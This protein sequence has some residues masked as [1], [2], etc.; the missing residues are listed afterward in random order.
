MEFTVHLK[1]G[2]GEGCDQHF[3]FKKFWKIFWS[4]DCQDVTWG[5]SVCITRFISY[6]SFSS[7]ERFNR[8]SFKVQIWNHNGLWGELKTV[9]FFFVYNID[10]ETCY[11]WVFSWYV[12]WHNTYDKL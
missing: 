5:L 4:L 8:F 6:K 7:V 10:I 3:P 2:F 11:Y 1:E 12:K 9:Y